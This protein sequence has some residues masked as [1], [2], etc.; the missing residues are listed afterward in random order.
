MVLYFK[1]DDKK[2]LIKTIAGRNYYPNNIDEC[3]DTLMII[4]DEIEMIMDN[5][6]KKGPIKR[7]NN[8]FPNGSSYKKEVGFLFK[9]E[10][11]IRIVCYDFS[12]KDTNSTDRLS[13]QVSTKEYN[14]WLRSKDKK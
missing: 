3:Y 11:F 13:V 1:T 8:S 5:A 2:Y 12:K 9:D 14:E 6:E 7:K 10:S 4:A